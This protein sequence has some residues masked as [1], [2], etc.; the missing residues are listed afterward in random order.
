M[1]NFSTGRSHRFLPLNEVEMSQR[2]RRSLPALIAFLIPISIAMLLGD[3]QANALVKPNPL[4]SDGVV[5]QQGMKIPVWGTA[6][7]GERVS[8]SFQ[9]QFASVVANK[10]GGWR[11]DLKPAQAGGPYALSITGS[12]QIKLKNVCVGEVFVCSGQSNMELPLS[13]SEGGEEVASKSNDPKLHLFTVSRR[14]SDKPSQVLSGQWDDASPAS[15]RGASAV[16]IYFGR[17][18]RKSLRVP[19]GLILAT[20]GGSP[21]QAWTSEKALFGNELLKPSLQ[22]LAV[23]RE[24]YAKEMETYPALRA[25][26]L[27]EAEAARATSSPVPVSPKAP[28]NPSNSVRSPSVLYNGMIAPLIPF[29]IRGVIWYQGEADTGEAWLYQ[30]SFPTMIANW[31]KDWGEGD[32][33]F[34]FVQLAPY[35]KR[36]ESP[37]ESAWAELREAQRLTAKR[38]ANTGMAVIADIGEEKEIQPRKKE[39]VGERLALLARKLVYRQKIAAEGPEFRSI[40]FEN[41]K[42]E[43]VFDNIEGGLIARETAGKSALLGFTIAG[44]DRVFHTAQAEISGNRVI[45]YSGDVVKPVAVRYGWANF[46]I[47]NLTNSAGLPA[48]PFRTDDFKLTTEPDTLK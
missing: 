8:V 22:A 39:P 17:S 16:A 6:S 26:Y 21:I 35:L 37:S 24:E 33:P 25:K 12:N 4:F 2:I 20:Y 30:T 19:V 47:G 7:P 11:I 18:L 10:S 43:V 36:R 13:L 32:F 1:A 44:E 42:A 34:L 48:S 27:L 9:K 40:V 38:T 46:P 23:S 3:G 45:V 14:L 29:G 15:V 28:A 41:G 5:L 31:R